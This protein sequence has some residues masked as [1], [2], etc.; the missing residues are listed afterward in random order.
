MRNALI[1]ICAVMLACTATV[2][3]QNQR[4][5]P[6]TLS[7][8]Q[9]PGQ[10]VP[11]T[12]RPGPANADVRPPSTVEVPPDASVVTIEGVCDGSQVSKTKDC[13]TV[14]T[15]AQ[16][17]SLSEMLIPGASQAVRRQFAINYARLLAASGAAEQ[18]HLEKDPEVVNQLQAEAK[19]ARMQVLAHALYQEIGKQAESVPAPEI[20]KYY[21]DH[22]SSFDQG[23]V[24]RLAIPRA[25]LG[26][27]GRPLDDSAV[28]AKAEELRQR[29][30]AGEDF[31]QLEHEAFI[32]LG[33]NAI[34]PPT[35]LNMVRRKNLPSEET[36]VFDLQPGEVTPVLESLG[37]LVVL[38]LVSKQS[39]AAAEAEPEIKALLRQDRMQQELE[40]AKKTITAQ[41]NLKYLDLT[42]EPEL[43]LPPAEA[44][45]S[46]ASRTGSDLRSQMMN[47]RGTTPDTRRAVRRPRF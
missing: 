18:K 27:D 20:Q 45:Q 14:V 23:E 31:E 37:Y 26:Q 9:L 19:F 4:R 21:E 24:L 40:S 32:N 11:G 16:M 10:G 1:L 33:V 3:A 35:K 22:L 8:G 30:V 38:K 41:F 34:A 29:A 5:N 39:V 17:E 43:F 15:R 7:S 42:S 13:K 25:V 2:I 44:Q 6:A 46:A 47:R 28:K 36:R 12:L